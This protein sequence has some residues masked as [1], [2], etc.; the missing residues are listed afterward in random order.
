MLWMWNKKTFAFIFGITECY[1]AKETI[2]KAIFHWRMTIEIYS[3]YKSCGLQSQRVAKIQE[4][5]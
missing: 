5:D 3:L 1:Q 4:S 2:S